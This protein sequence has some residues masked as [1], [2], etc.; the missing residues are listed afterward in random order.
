MSTLILGIWWLWWAIGSFG[1]VGCAILLWLAPTLLASMAT[2]FLS[3]VLATPIGAALAAGAIAFF[4]ADVNRSI[5]DQR[6]FSA[7]TAA[8]QQAQKQREAQIAKETRD[9]VSAELS[10]QQADHAKLDQDV[11]EF[12]GALPPVP[13]V[14]G[15]DPFR[16]GD[17]SCRLRSLAGYAGCGSAGAQ[18]V[19]KVGPK[20]KRPR[21]INRP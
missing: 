4:V 14:N 16:V 7:I 6:E 1:V 15:T 19:P 17:A 10:A 9:Q 21:P 3:F 13:F 12:K 11:K 18:G 2:R 20:G 5:I 8:S